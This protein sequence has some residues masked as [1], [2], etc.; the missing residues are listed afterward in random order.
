MDPYFVKI[1]VGCVTSI[2][3]ERYNITAA[4]YTQFPLSDKS[5]N[6]QWRK[7]NGLSHVCVTAVLNI[8]EVLTVD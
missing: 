7:C 8:S 2:K 3:H 1:T 4:M 6:L 5:D